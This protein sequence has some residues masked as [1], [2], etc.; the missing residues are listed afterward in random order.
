MKK[1]VVLSSVA[2]AMLLFSGCSSNKPTVDQTATKVAPTANSTVVT[3][4]MESS[5]SNSSNTASSSV[6]QNAAEQ[7]ASN[8]GS[9]AAMSIEDVQKTMSSVFF[10]FDKFEIRDDMKANVS[11]DSGIAKA[12]AAAYKVK[13]EG[14]CD[15]WGSDEYNDALGL[16]RAQTV[17][18]ALVNDGVDASRITMVSLGKTSPVCKDKTKECWA[19]NRRVDFKLLP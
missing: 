1:S 8:A 10:D 7:S 11:N 2:V 6:A 3:P 5:S 19:Q 15:E 17:K 9:N 13:L 12:A 14:N 4:S 18:A 16:K